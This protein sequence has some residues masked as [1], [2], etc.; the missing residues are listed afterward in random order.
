[1]RQT[2]KK[3]VV[4]RGGA[5]PSG[6]AGANKQILRSDIPC[7]AFSCTKC[8]AAS[9]NS[10]GTV[11]CLLPDDG[12]AVPDAGS[13]ISYMSAWENPLLSNVMV[14]GSVLSD[15]GGRNRAIATRLKA[16]AA[17]PD[18]R[19]YVF[20]N[21]H[22][23]DASAPST[24][25]VSMIGSNAE[26]P[27]DGQRRL[28]SAAVGWLAAHWASSAEA[29]AGTSGAPH[30]IPKVI[31]ISADPAMGPAV[32]AL[33]LPPSAVHVAT[34]LE[35][36]TLC[37]PNADSALLD[38]VSVAQAP[39]TAG[40]G[41]FGAPTYWGQPW[42]T[43]QDAK[44]RVAS[45][46]LVQGK[47]KM[48]ESS[49]FFGELRGDFRVHVPASG[50][51][52]T[53]V[54]CSRVL[55]IGRYAINRTFHDDVVA[56]QV[57]PVEEWKCPDKFTTDRVARG[58]VGA[59][60]ALQLGCVPTAN[61]VALL[62]PNRRPYCGSIDASEAVGGGAGGGGFGAGSSV[63][64]QPKSSR[65]PRI[66]LL[67]RSAEDLRGKRIVVV[68]DDWPEGSAHPIGHYI[69]ILG[70]IGDKDTEARVILMERDIPHY[71]FSKAVY[72]CL[73]QGQWQVEEAEVKRRRDCRHL[74][75]CSVDPLGCRDIDDALHF[76][77]LPGESDLVEVGVHIADVSHFVQ[78]GT[79][80]DLEAQKRST[81]V[82]LVDRRINMLP[83]LLTE[84][85][86]SIV[87]NEDR[88]A[89]SFIWK[90]RPSTCEIVEEWFGKMIIR[91]RAALYYGHA[92]AMID[93]ASDHSEL[94]EGLRG[95]LRL[96]RVLK[97]QRNAKGA[98]ELASQEFK[99]A[100]D[101]DHVNPTDMTQYRTFE[102]NSMVEEWMLFANIAAARACYK[103]Y[104]QWALLR[105]HEM[106]D[107]ASFVE[108]NS[109]L[110]RI[111]G[112]TL[113]PTSSGALNAGLA[114]CVH[115]DDPNFNI[116]IRTLTTR[117]LKQAQYFTS[118]DHP[119]EAFSH[120]GLAMPI[121]THFTSP[122]RRYAD[123]VVH[124]QLAAI[125]G[126]LGVS[127][128][129]TNVQKMKEVV[130][131]INYRHEMAQRAGRDSQNL[132]TGFFMRT[133]PD[134]N[135]PDT[136]GY[137]IRVTEAA[138]TVMV[139]KYGQE[140]KVTVDANE[141]DSAGSGGLVT[142]ENVVPGAIRLS[143]D[144]APPTTVAAGRFELLQKVHTR[145]RLASEGHGDAC[146][147]K[148]NFSILGAVKASRRPADE[149][150]DENRPAQP[151]RIN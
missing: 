137:V 100:I 11:P 89:F 32:A 86:C 97:T 36:V 74:S 113:D 3:A 134:G 115:P 133:F 47:V 13:W 42:L 94:A 141:L 38:Q 92:Q 93:D 66:K 91:S 40:Q 46:A 139:P 6:L 151:R 77:P 55:L 126:R 65:I 150:G 123:V 61:V 78:E 101:N 85:L 73:P 45:G 19:C 17:R 1:M 43:E 33:G 16:L 48:S 37:H 131:N 116:L 67:T 2:T 72:D 4:V 88:Y 12:V 147:V 60:E 107:P 15:V 9:D 96:A 54:T 142:T 49:S 35:Y 81:S 44:S 114:R 76:R 128:E 125:I 29:A 121:Y 146:A 63:M 80:M 25:R 127:D 130:Q 69:D 98:L 41:K 34:M 51:S 136:E 135:I 132:F 59:D 26:T 124:R 122:I 82:Y 7:G 129:H 50:G 99:F 21:E 106:P 23:H 68:A 58:T 90:M 144:A 149:E 18:K 10:G 105:R 83:Q 138:L 118:G 22:H 148:L 62:V 70:P 79:A 20:S 71:D 103:H 84:N 120:F 39:L 14:L 24:A 104:P 102:T 87:G 52:A 5:Q 75:I 27:A 53:P 110:K 31:V 119:Y 57:R 28:I 145:I 140:G 108:L 112:F 8:A 117:C 95:L 64:F 143:D 109:A 56:A 111:I 30:P